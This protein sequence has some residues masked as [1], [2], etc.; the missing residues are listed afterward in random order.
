MTESQNGISIPHPPVISTDNFI[1]SLVDGKESPSDLL[2]SV[3]APPL[4]LILRGTD[5]TVT[6]EQTRQLWAVSYFSCQG[7][8]LQEARHTDKEEE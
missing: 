8:R 2:P 3:P 1:Q 4:I 7:P 5:V 6:K